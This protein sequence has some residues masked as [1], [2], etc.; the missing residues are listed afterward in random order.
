MTKEQLKEW[1]RENQV[2][3]TETGW[4]SDSPTKIGLRFN[5]EKDPFTY[6]YI[7]EA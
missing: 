2:L 3:D 6:V 7:A 5:D 4:D 1:L